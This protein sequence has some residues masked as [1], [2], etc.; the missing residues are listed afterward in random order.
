MLGRYVN[1]SS[2]CIVGFLSILAFENNYS[3]ADKL[4]QIFLSSDIEHPLSSPMTDYK[5]NSGDGKI[6]RLVDSQ[7][8]AIANRSKLIDSYM[9]Q[10]ENIVE[11]RKDRNNL[12]NGF[13]SGILK[14]LPTN[15]A[16]FI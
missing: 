6:R 1:Q 7:E 14:L 3:T 15:W 16:I 13:L 11:A 9:A 2:N 12:F 5:Q 8:K 10:L 4:S